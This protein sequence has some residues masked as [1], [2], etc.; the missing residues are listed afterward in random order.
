MYDYSVKILHI[1]KNNF[2]RKLRMVSEMRTIVSRKTESHA[3]F[4]K[5]ARFQEGHENASKYG[6]F[7]V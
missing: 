7:F 2:M 6:C 5:I 4:T 1:L 3:T